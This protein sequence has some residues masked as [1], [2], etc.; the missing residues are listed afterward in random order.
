[1]ETSKIKLVRRIFCRLKFF[2]NFLFSF[3][4]LLRGK[5][6]QKQDDTKF[7]YFQFKF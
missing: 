2:A 3:L 4:S 7:G 1:M 5:M 6:L